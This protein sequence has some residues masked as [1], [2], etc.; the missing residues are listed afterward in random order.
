MKKN[1]KAMEMEMLT[2]LII[3]I[4]ILAIIL[5]SYMILKDKG[6]NYIEYIK[7]LFSFGR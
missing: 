6:I 3:G 4:V 5:F 1:K 7:N 2:Y